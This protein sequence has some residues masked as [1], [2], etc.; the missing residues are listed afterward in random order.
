MIRFIVSSKYVYRIYLQDEYMLVYKS[1]KDFI[2]FTS[3][4]VYSN[5]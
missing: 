4:H 1:V 5:L 3:E 2:E